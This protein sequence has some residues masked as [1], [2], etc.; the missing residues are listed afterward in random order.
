MVRERWASGRQAE[1][2]L[3]RGVLCGKGRPERPGSIQRPRP[4]VRSWTGDSRGFL[5]TSALRACARNSASEPWREAH[6][7]G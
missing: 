3:C 2:D 5:F 4:F 6:S 1:A 7:A